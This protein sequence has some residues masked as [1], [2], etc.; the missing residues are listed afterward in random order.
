M[1]YDNQV[2]YSMGLTALAL[3]IEAMQDKAPEIEDDFDNL[4][5]LLLEYAES[6]QDDI[7]SARDN[8]YDEGYADC[9][10]ELSGKYQEGFDDGHRE[11]YQEGYNEGYEQGLEDSDEE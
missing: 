5:T 1:R 8:G 11:G 7:A 10:W 9:D 3:Q 2:L 4:S 6:V